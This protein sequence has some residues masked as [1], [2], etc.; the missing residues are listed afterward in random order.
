MDDVAVATGADV[1]TVRAD[2]AGF[3][4]FVTAHGSRLLRTAFL[5]T[6]EHGAAEDLLQETFVRAWSRWSLPRQSRRA[7]DGCGS[8]G[9]PSLAT[10]SR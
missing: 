10:P 3:D 4:A 9:R 1:R 8:G 5:L 6:G 2:T 7:A